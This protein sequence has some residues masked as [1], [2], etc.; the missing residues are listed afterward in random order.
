M[1]KRDWSSIESSPNTE[2]PHWTELSGLAISWPVVCSTNRQRPLA[3]IQLLTWSYDTNLERYRSGTA[4][5]AP[6]QP[7][8]QRF[9]FPL[10]H[11]HQ[12]ICAVMPVRNKSGLD[13]APS[14]EKKRIQNDNDLNT[15]GFI[16]QVED[17]WRWSGQALVWQFF[18]NS[19]ESGAS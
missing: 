2:P 11:V 9:M 15:W 4:R 19:L 13:L 1:C 18:T 7:R 16:S 12:I 5:V 10:Q 17:I 3:Q 8:T 6:L 14:G